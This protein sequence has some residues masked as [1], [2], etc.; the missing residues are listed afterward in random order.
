MI[1]QR[2]SPAANVKII[3]VDKQ[4]GGRDDNQHE[5]HEEANPA[6]HFVPPSTRGETPAKEK[7]FECSNSDV[8]GKAG[9]FDDGASIPCNTETKSSEAV[10]EQR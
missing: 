7:Y 10:T 9:D 3:Q 4:P 8:D 5:D 1:T 6:N 2:A